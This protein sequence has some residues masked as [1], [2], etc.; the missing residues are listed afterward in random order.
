VKEKLLW[1][2]C[3]GW[4]RFIHILGISEFVF[5][6]VVLIVLTLGGGS[7][8]GMLLAF[9]WIGSIGVLVIIAIYRGTYLERQRKVLVQNRQR[10]L[11]PYFIR[12]SVILNKCDRNCV[13]A[14]RWA[15]GKV[16]EFNPNIIYPEDTADTLP[17]LFSP[18]RFEGV[19]HACNRLGVKIKDEEVDRIGESISKAAN[20]A[21][22]ISLFEQAMSRADKE[23]V[24]FEA[25]GIVE[26]KTSHKDEISL[27]ELRELADNSPARRYVNLW[28]LKRLKRYPGSSITFTQNKSLPE[29]EEYEGELIPSFEEV[30]DRVKKMVGMKEILYPEQVEGRTKLM[31][32][33]GQTFKNIELLVTLC[34]GQEDAF[35]ELSISDKDILEIAEQ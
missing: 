4:N 24:G 1:G 21:E 15:L 22:M 8:T 3:D 12:N 29:I 30:S 7:K 11:I 13:R 25:K 10:M 31:F 17:V 6:F 16:Y 33:N 23:Y 18:L 28:I 32:G 14:M 5:A 19:L 27:D 34:D 26:Q 20:V 9:S 2:H 35:V